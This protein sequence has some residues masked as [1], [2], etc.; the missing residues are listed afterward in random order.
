MHVMHHTGLPSV[1]S[2]SFLPARC[3]AILWELLIKRGF[4]VVY[5][6]AAS[7]R[8]GHA[9]TIVI[10]F[11]VLLRGGFSNLFSDSHFPNKR[12][13]SGVNPASSI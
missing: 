11:A 10:V 6:N 7:F 5:V 12:D 2:L 4:F 8:H 9:Q 3:A 1:L 13:C